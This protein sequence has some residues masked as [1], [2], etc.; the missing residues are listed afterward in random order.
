MKKL[1]LVL[2]ATLLFAQELNIDINSL[3][4]YVK[5]NPQDVNNRLILTS[6]YIKKGDYKNA[7]TLLDEVLKLEPENKKALE[8]KEKVE[9]LKN[10]AVYKKYFS[11]PNDYITKLYNT[12]DYKDLTLFYK[13]YTLIK[14]YKNLSDDSLFK[15]AR[16]LMWNGKYE[17]SLK[18]LDR[19]RNKKSLDYYEIAAYNYYY[20]G[21]P[22]AVK[23]FKILY[24]ATGKTE[25]AK[26]ILDFYLQTKDINAAKKLLLSLKYRVGK[27]FTDYYYNKI[28]QIEK[29]Y[30][31]ELYKKYQ[32]D[33]TYENLKR[34]VMALYNVDKQRAYSIL[35]DY[36]EKNPSNKEAKILFAELLSWDGNTDEALKYLKDLKNSDT[37][38]KLLIGKILAW[39]GNYP[40]A[41]IYL[42]DVYDHGL[43][44]ER[45]E[46]LKMLGFIAMWQNKKEKAKEIFQKLY[47]QNP[48]D[49]EVKENLM[50]LNG[51]IMPVIKKYKALLANDPNNAEYILKLADLYYMLKDYK[52]AAYYYERY[53]ILHPEKL[54]AYKTLGDIYL[55]MKDYYKGY[56]NWEYY[57][58]A[59]NTKEAYYN[60]ALRYYWHGFNKEALKVLDDLLQK[61]PNYQEAVLLKAKLLKIN[62]RF[63][64]SS[65]AAT[66]DEYFNNRAKKLLVYGDRAYFNN[67][68]ATAAD[69]YHEYLSINPDDYE[70]RE[71]YAYALE[72]DKKYAKAAGEFFLLMWYKKNP[73]IEYHYAYNLQKSGNIKKAK[74]IYKK[75]LN[76]MP[77]PLPENLKEF[78]ENWK[79]AWESMDFKKYAS[80]Y[81][82]KI[83]N[84]IYWR[85]RKQNI[86]KNAGFISV[87]IY[88]PVLIKK[89]DDVYVVKFY[90]EY[91]SQKK[92]DKGYKT[93]WIRCKNGVCK[94]IKEKWQAGEYVPFN[95]KNSLKTYILQNLNLIEK[96]EKPKLK[97][98]PKTQP[99]ETNATGITLPRP[100]EKETK[101]KDI[102]LAPRLKKNKKN[103]EELLNIT[104]L[105]PVR[106]NELNTVVCKDQSKIYPWELYL[107]YDYFH[108]NQQTTMHT[109][110]SKIYKKIKFEKIYFL[111]NFY[112]LTQ[113][114]E[115][116]Y[117]H[118]IGGGLQKDNWYF[119]VFGSF[120]YKKN[121]GFNFGYRFYDW[122]NFI[123]SRNNLAY[124]RRTICATRHM[125]VKGEITNY[126]QLDDTRG[127]WY[128][129][130]YERV[131]D[132]NNVITPQIDYDFYGFKYQNTNFALYFS[133]WYQFNSQE[134][135]CYFSPSKTDS[136][137]IGIKA[138][139]RLSKY[140]KL[141]AQAGGGYSFWD[142]NYLYSLKAYLQ[143]TTY[144]TFYTKLGCELSNSSKQT[145]NTSGYRSY[146]CI[147]EL[148]K[149]W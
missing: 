19:V 99:K 92:K 34:V 40:Q 105:A 86:F 115:T 142:K 71:K 50:I 1:L 37:K 69:Y 146:E 138:D 22:K 79:K 8:L 78:I 143:S 145:I 26:A 80:F 125:V 45:Y 56:G 114:S 39:Q 129:L 108:D 13:Y 100:I 46:A 110:Y 117:G 131:D 147:W 88:D 91:A 12:N 20:L 64:E 84:N 134:N 133:G 30:I 54:E 68:Y 11:N 130:A 59:K 89:E 95:E 124:S 25:Y 106:L 38:A 53:L 43:P 42:S 60:L 62:P 140:W 81:D 18:A 97:T 126:R 123:L 119:D 73:T 113:K 90:Q 98:L 72:N 141:H 47:K 65:T 6:Y 17:E 16:V 14:G 103:P 23:Y 24:N 66:I 55:E 74:E 33:P 139:K 27:E 137:I 107:K 135:E 76:E 9:M 10:A 67:L 4:E 21:D 127:L 111:Y 3:K 109:V 136:N 51:N 112:R 120:D 122:F 132:G 148:D 83:A 36:I 48:K 32:K 52:N 35:K 5:N 75:L 102:L 128:S 29:E 2:A 61:Y 28:D 57:A 93:L 44:Q 121:V 70:V 85:L 58:Q 82:K 116:K 49:E 96:Q 101:K 63:V 149:K 104:K 87:G 15:V 77:K 118:Q 94:I 144:K 41:V 7:K 31:E